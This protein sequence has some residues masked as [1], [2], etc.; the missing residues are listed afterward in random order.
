MRRAS[1]LP[2]ALAAALVLAT[3]CDP[4]SSGS[5]SA[6]D[7]SIMSS[8]RLTASELASWF[9]S[10]KGDSHRLPVSIDTLAAY[11]IE[12]GN[13]E[14]VRGDIAFAQ[15]VLETGW[16]WFPDGG[17]V[18]PWYNNYGGI[19]AVD[20]GS[21]PAR[22]SSPREGVRAQ[23]QHLRAYGDP[24]VTR[25]SLAHRL[26][27]PRFDLVTPK[28]KALTWYELS[29]T[30]ATS[31][32]YGQRIVELYAD[33]ARL[34]GKAIVPARAIAANP[35]GGYYVLYGDGVIEARA[36]APDFGQ[37]SF[38]FDI[39]RD[40]EVMPDGAG[41]VVLDGWGGLHKF[42]SAKQGAMKNIYGPYWRGWDIANALAIT[43]G[44][45][46]L[47]VLD[48]WGGLHARGNA[49]VVYGPYWREWDIARDVELDDRN[50]VYVLDGWG[51]V[52]T[53]NGAVSRG[54]PYW[55]GWDI[56]RD[57]V[58]MPDGRGYAILDGW[59]AIHNRGSAP[60]GAGGMW[61]QVDRWIGASWTG[62]SYVAVQ[63][64]GASATG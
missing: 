3:G 60:P 59:G 7:P 48:G 61:A 43:A 30:W 63:R 39:A 22:F 23:I 2:L 9:R 11:F 29:G 46:G 18:R 19:G 1:L 54:N 40:I 21:N 32:T 44:G 53:R 58:V 5:G 33:A 31:T 25:D 24:T 28:G 14:G 35:N 49:P 17:Q 27:D 34:A 56:A 37:P 57:L 55:E 12:E 15:S 64:G 62:S 41:Y 6:Q 51:G 52:H 10:V 26:V 42:G 13:D 20:G 4:G 45:N 16:F 36:G 47:I 50:G 38:T 8:S